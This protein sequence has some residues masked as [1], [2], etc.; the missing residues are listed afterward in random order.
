MADILGA[1]REA[2]AKTP[3]SL[4]MPCHEGRLTRPG[5]DPGSFPMSTASILITAAILAQPVMVLSLLAMGV[6]N[7]GAVRTVR[8]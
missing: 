7:K 8:A 6:M 3:L 1:L 4:A 2:Q 5:P